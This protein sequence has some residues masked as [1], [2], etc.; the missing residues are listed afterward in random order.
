MIAIPIMQA[1]LMS[2][3]GK[4]WD[5]R[6]WGRAFMHLW[7]SPGIWRRVMLGVFAYMAPGFHPENRTVSPEV[8]AWRHYYRATKIRDRQGPAIFSET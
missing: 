6:A 3:R 8:L 5:M 1:W 7:I 2:K 4:L